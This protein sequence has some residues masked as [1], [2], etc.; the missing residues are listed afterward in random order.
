MFR[1]ALR[2][3]KGLKLGLRTL[4]LEEARRVK[5]FLNTKKGTRCIIITEAYFSGEEEFRE[6]F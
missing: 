1:I 5:A 6:I 4:T 3:R 2:T